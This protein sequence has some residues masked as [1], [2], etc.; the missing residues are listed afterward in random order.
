MNTSDP[1]KA[2][3]DNR[4]IYN[5]RLNG[6]RLS[7]NRLSW[8][9]LLIIVVA[10]VFAY[11]GFRN[12]QALFWILAGS[13]FMGFLALMAVH[14]RMGKRVK[15]A[16]TL[17][18]LNEAEIAF[19]ETGKPGFP[20]GTIYQQTQH[21]YNYDLDLFGPFSL[22]HHLNRSKTIMGTAQLA[23]TLQ[24]RSSNETIINRQQAVRELVPL[25]DWRQDYMAKAQLAGDSEKIVRALRSWTGE[26]TSLSLRTIVLSYLVPVI[27]GSLMIAGLLSDFNGLLLNLAVTVFIFNLLILASQLKNMNREIAHA[28]KINETL[29]RYS[30]LLRAIEGQNWKSP[31]LSKLQSELSAFEP[32][33]PTASQH[34]HRLSRIFAS[35]ESLQNG[36]GAILFN[37][38][39]LYHLHAYR[40]LLRWKTEHSAQLNTWLEQIGELEVLISF[41]NLSFNNPDFCYPALNN[42]HALTF[43]ALGH[44][45]IPSTRRVAND[46]DFTQRSFIILTG[47][48]MSGKSTFLRTLGIN[49]VLA[50]AGAPICAASASLH[51]MD[52]LVSMR[53][54]DSLTD[55]ESY[56]FAEVRRLKE[57]MDG[58]DDHRCFILLDEILRGTN[59]DDKRTGTIEVVKKV[60]AKK[61]IGAIATH[62]LEVCNTT[63]EFPDILTNKC[64]EVEI[65]DNELHFDYRLR[66]GI[67]QNK[68]ATFL[69]QK[70]GVI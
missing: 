48:N 38:T 46:V 24:A 69:M 54:S 2:Y 59:S 50:N 34:I 29:L 62:D 22:F 57:I 28:D 68:S 23:E 14:S 39:V 21:P 11:F 9:R 7:Y 18:D 37:G 3:H 65:L 56:F 61:A 12:Q 8:A 41:A 27:G 66:D 25:L 63:G 16:Q 1:L 19:I 58:L 30:E 4:G 67:C 53:L 42:N 60:I 31:Q 49:L 36:F 43:E 47:S 26:K 64:F 51:P 6:L 13:A 33:S 70:M 15:L 52:I 10:L 40:K 20:D 32:G 35:L 55:S 45:L 5:E 44:P 17:V